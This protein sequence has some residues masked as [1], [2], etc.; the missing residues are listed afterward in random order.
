MANKVVTTTAKDGAKIEFVIKPDPPEGAMKYVFFS[1]QKDYVVAFFKKRQ[2]ARSMSRLES[3]TGKYRS[4][5]Y[6]QIGGDFWK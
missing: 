2:D 5:I 3:I 4:D 1:P 6:D